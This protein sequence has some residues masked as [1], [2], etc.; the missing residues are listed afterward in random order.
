MF[1]SLPNTASYQAAL[2][3]DPLMVRPT[4]TLVEVVQRM[5]Q[6]RL[7]CELVLKPDSPPKVLAEARSSCVLVIDDGGTLRGIVTERDLVRLGVE[8]HNWQ[9]AIAEAVMTSP[10][11]ALP[12]AQL[13]D[14]FVV[15]EQFRVHRIRHLPVLDEVG[16]VA[17]L[18]THDSLRLVTR[19]IDLMRFQTVADTM[20][21]QVITASPQ[22]SLL[23]INHLLVQN[24]ISCVVIVE[25]QDQLPDSVRPVGMITERDLVQLRSLDLDFSDCQVSQVMAQHLVTVHGQDTLLEVQNL[26]ETHQV[27][28]VVVLGD[29]GELL[30]LV[31]PT[32][33]LG[34]LNPWEL[35][36]LT[37]SLEKRV[38][39][40][41][42][43]KIALLENQTRALEQEV[44]ARTRSL[45]E[46]YQQE[47]LVTEI[48]NQI[49]SSLAL[50]EILQTTV[51]E[52]QALF[53]CDRVAVWQCDGHGILTAIAE[54][55]TNHVRSQLGEQVDD[56]CFRERGLD[57]Y[58]AGEMWVVADFNQQTMTTC[59]Q[60]LMERLQI[61]A[62]ILVAIVINHRLWGL[63]EASESQCA[64]EWS[65]HEI[66]LLQSLST[67]LA[68]A[69][70][71]AQTHQSLTDLSQQLE[72]RVIERT[73]SLEATLQQ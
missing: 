1:D 71:Q 27:H 33:V 57:N 45:E 58:G 28:Q 11:L 30:G 52:I 46:K 64:R 21:H 59:Y 39:S 69:I 40:L 12:L 61:R 17:G 7:T 55:K 35:F 38:A 19:P 6:A 13:T 16:Q 73:A 68:I 3:T 24:H 42:S 10:V 48:A 53:H 14:M 9:G 22:T 36:R 5:N 56:P 50:P 62:K 72:Q 25:S 41:E 18:I 49:R 60:A 15:L 47:Q 54:A 66:N 2:I 63:L 43:E 34:A 67:Q 32:N 20:T 23:K 65:T 44:V 8:Q 29:A 31:T 4:D 37:E 26:M 70:D 51:T